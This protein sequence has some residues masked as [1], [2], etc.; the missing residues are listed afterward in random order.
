MQTRNG[1]TLFTGPVFAIDQFDARMGG[2]V[3]HTF[4]VIRHPGGV[5]VLPLHDDGTVTL[6]RQ[7]RPAVAASLLEIPA[8]RLDPAESTEECGRR[9]LREETGLESGDLRPLGAI[10]SSPGVFDEVIH[11]YLARTLTQHAPAPEEDEFLEPVRLPLADALQMA[12]DGRISDAKTI[13][14][15]FRAEASCQ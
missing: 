7:A 5:G 13:I 12:R 9:E 14:A 15:L 3:W 11:L 6:I 2:S 1:T 8:G 10:H 4:Q